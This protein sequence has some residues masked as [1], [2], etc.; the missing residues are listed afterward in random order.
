M[1]V[2]SLTRKRWAVRARQRPLRKGLSALGPLSGPLSF[3]NAVRLHGRLGS[4][5]L[6][7]RAA[8]RLSLAQCRG[9]EEVHIAA[10][11]QEAWMSKPY[12]GRDACWWILR[13][14]GAGVRCTRL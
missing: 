1:R 10:G 4:V 6:S 5:P 9:L 8:S 7:A 12:R 3:D 11:P 2:T 14:R 13:L